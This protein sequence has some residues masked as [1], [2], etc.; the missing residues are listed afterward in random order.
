MSRTKSGSSRAG[1]RLAPYLL[2]YST[3]FA[4][5]IPRYLKSFRITTFKYEVKCFRLGFFKEFKVVVFFFYLRCFPLNDYI[6]RFHHYGRR[7]VVGASL[8][9]NTSFCLRIRKP[10]FDDHRLWFSWQRW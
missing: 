8:I 10:S 4:R 1:L 2:T 3:G 5:I 7:F 9:D 6:S